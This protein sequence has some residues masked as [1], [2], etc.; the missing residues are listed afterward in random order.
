[1]LIRV[2]HFSWMFIGAD[3]WL[4]LSRHGTEASMRMALVLI[5]AQL[6]CAGC[7]GHDPT[8]EE[9]ARIY[10]TG[11]TRADVAE[12]FR[13]EGS[14]EKPMKVFVRPVQ[15]WESSPLDKLYEVGPLLA[16]YER[17]HP[18]L[19]AQTCEVRWVPRG[20]MG[21]GVYWDYIWF[22]EGDRLLG[23]KRRFVD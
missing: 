13:R 19:V 23:F 21:M 17:E 8:N 15:G 14:D 10:H 11:M 4:R 12:L 20:F 1:V 5:V 3:R 22:D 2:P 7:H 9:L 6:L 16:K 18:G